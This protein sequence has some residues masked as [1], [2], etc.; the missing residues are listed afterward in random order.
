MVKRAII[1]VL[2]SVG[3][4]ALPDAP[5]FDSA[6]AHTLGHIYEARGRLNLPNLTN[7]GLGA[8]EDSRLPSPPK[9]RLVGA[10]GRAM[11]QARGK[12]TISG[13]W[14]LMGY[15]LD[16]PFRTFPEGFPEALMQKFEA[17]IGRGTLGNYVASGTTIIN[18][19]GDEHV[20]TGKPIVYTSADSVF[21]IAA[22]EEV[23]PLEKL[24]RFCEAAR[25]LL[26]GDYLVGRV[27]A[28]P[29]LGENGDYHRTE[30]RKDFSVPPLGATVLDGLSVQGL[31]TYGIGKIQ[32]IF[33]R[34]GVMKSIHTHTNQEGVDAILDALS[35]RNDRLVLANLVDFDMLYGHRNDVEGYASAL[36]YFDGRLE[37]ILAAMTEQDLLII[38]ADHGCDPTYPGTDHTREYVPVLCYHKGM[39]GPVELGTL[40]SYADVGATAYE[41]ICGIKWSVGQSFLERLSIQ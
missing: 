12:D 14:E 26:V 7:L 8:I 29:F 17:K 3:I 20:K 24:Y 2:D 34:R 25:S 16:K 28:R 27:I 40:K 36:E 38:T 22:H 18:V 5:D 10:Y 31:D 23:I 37:E 11:E 35:N 30:N 13:H 6:G 39:T 1:I 21:Q 4:G 19:L 32:D 33:A 15:V 9:E 41:Y